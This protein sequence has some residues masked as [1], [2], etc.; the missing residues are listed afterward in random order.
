MSIIN[1]VPGLW[2]I[3]PTH[4][5]F[6]GETLRASQVLLAPTLASR[7]SWALPGP[8]SR[9]LLFYCRPTPSALRLPTP[10]TQQVSRSIK[11]DHEHRRVALEGGTG[12]WHWGYE[13]AWLVDNRHEVFSPPRHIAC[14]WSMFLKARCKIWKNKCCQKPSLTSV[15][16]IPSLALR[17]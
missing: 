10:I 6:P 7:I 17:N 4:R 5:Q 13:H 3:H 2:L 11:P 16:E 9:C 1:R 8:A 15:R 12:G 14:L